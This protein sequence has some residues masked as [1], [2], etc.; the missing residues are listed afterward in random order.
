ML[1]A[2]RISGRGRAG[3][4]VSPGIRNVWL[5]VYGGTRRGEGPGGEGSS[6]AGGGNEQGSLPHP[7]L[8]YREL[9]NNTGL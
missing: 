5:Y 4:R 8:R 3:A 7:P 1:A 6:A 9:S 2:T